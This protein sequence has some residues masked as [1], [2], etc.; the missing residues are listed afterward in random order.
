MSV[1]ALTFGS[2]GDIIAVI[3]LA[4]SIQKALSDSAGSST[5][6]KKLAQY[7]DHFTNALRSVQSMLGLVPAIAAE[8]QMHDS[9]NHAISASFRLLKEFE[10]RFERYRRRLVE[11]AITRD[12]VRRMLKIWYSLK[13]LAIR[14]SAADL[15][16]QLEGYVHIINVTLTSCICTA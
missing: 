4:Y 6:C 15:Q 3:Q 12:T 13:W 10:G 14:S 9:V 11:D 2:F 16:R 7:L 1:V 5:E 8:H